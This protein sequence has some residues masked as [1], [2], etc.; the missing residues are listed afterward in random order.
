MTNKLI[1]MLDSEFDTFMCQ[2]FPG[3]FIQRHQDMSITCM[4]WGFCIG[5]GWRNILYNLC[6]DLQKICDKTKIDI[7][8][9]QIKEKYGSARFYYDTRMPVIC[10]KLKLTEINNEILLLINESEDK[11][12][13]TCAA[14]GKEYKRKKQET[15][16]I[17]SICN[18]CDIIRNRYKGI[19]INE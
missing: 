10:D 17:K 1:D 5:R 15:G 7:Q 11:T 12:Y 9:T 8:F 4:C 2:S 3:L 13:T 19:N 18:N 16:W 14:C 6:L